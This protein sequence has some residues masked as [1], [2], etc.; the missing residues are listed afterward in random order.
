MNGTEYMNRINQITYVEIERL[1]PLQLVKLL[2]ILLHAEARKRGILKTG[3]HVP[4][5]IVVADGGEDGRWDAPLE[6]SDYIPNKF[7]V[8]QSKA[9]GIG[10]AQ[11]G[12]EI[13]K[14]RKDPTKDPIELKPKVREALE[15]GGCYCFF[16]KTN[17]VQDGIDKRV[18]TVRESLKAA[19][20]PNPEHDQI[21]FLDG[22]KIAAWVNQHAGAIS[23]V[24][25]SCKLMRRDS[26]LSWSAWGKL[27]SDFKFPF[28]S[29]AYLDNHIKTLQDDLAKPKAIA[30]IAANCRACIRGVCDV[31]VPKWRPL[32]KM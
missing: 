7:T 25:E 5:N 2:H 11:C 26:F 14:K 10:I 16:C 22:N 9:E 27:R 8:Y 19:G 1:D 30:R 12:K 6:P 15:K 18:A 31:Y 21:A 13:L 24:I 32:G 28:E 20:R 23:F 17:Y 4:L 29:N 3:I